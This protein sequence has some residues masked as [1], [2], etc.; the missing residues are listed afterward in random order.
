MEKTIKQI[1]TIDGFICKNIQEI[2]KYGFLFFLTKT[3][4]KR[5]WSDKEIWLHMERTKNKLSKTII[6]YETLYKQLG[7]RWFHKTK[8]YNK[9]EKRWFSS[10]TRKNVWTKS[11][12][13]FKKKQCSFWKS[14]VSNTKIYNLKKSMDSYNKP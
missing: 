5:K 6:S 14:I 11:T 4:F 9:L 8:P 13:S 2:R 12:D 1:Q 10:K 7:N 3:F